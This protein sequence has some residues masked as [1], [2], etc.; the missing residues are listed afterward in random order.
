MGIIEEV[1]FTWQYMCAHKSIGS[2]DGYGGQHQ[3]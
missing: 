1:G 2:E 3:L